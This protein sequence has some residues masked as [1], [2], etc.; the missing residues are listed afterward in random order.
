MKCSTFQPSCL[1]SSSSFFNPDPRTYTLN[2]ELFKDLQ[3][4]PTRPS[5]Q[6]CSCCQ[7]AAQCSI[8]CLERAAQCLACAMHGSP[9]L[10]S[11]G[12]HVAFFFIR[13][14]PGVLPC[15]TSAVG[16]ALPG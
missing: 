7:A 11:F 4:Y 2:P 6:V 13:A 8:V 16:L 12:L 1:A 3:S 5:L 15:M 9:A 14:L 10:I